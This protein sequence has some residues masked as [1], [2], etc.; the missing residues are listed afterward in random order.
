DKG[1]RCGY[2]RGRRRR[3]IVDRIAGTRSGSWWWR[4]GGR[5]FAARAALSERKV[6]GG[7]ELRRRL[8]RSGS[9]MP[10]SAMT[11]DTY[12]HLFPRGDDGKELAEAEL[13]LIG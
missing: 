4:R 9:A 1:P 11:L 3:A 8:S 5:P 6:D 7:L 12:G 2:G 13:R 10:T